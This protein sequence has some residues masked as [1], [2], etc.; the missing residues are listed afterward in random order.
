L[1][2]ELKMKKIIASIILL[3]I[4]GCTPYQPSGFLGGYSETQLSPDVFRINFRGNGYTSS[5]RT[6]DFAMLR[7]SELTIKEGFKYFALINETNTSKTST[8]TTSGSAYTTGSSNIY[9]RNG[10]YSGS[11]S[12]YTTYNPPQTHYISKPRSELMIQCFKEKPEEIYI[13]DAEFLM[14]SIKKKYKLK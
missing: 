6:G 5:E 14:Q 9:G 3:F 11:Y 7:A 1:K 2:G 10:S 12:G 4:S 13:F 8:Y